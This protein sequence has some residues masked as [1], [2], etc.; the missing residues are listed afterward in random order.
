MAYGTYEDYAALFGADNLTREQYAA[1]LPRATAMLDI[2]TARRAQEATGYKLEA[3]KRAESALVNLLAAQDDTMQG[4][5][6]SSVSNEGYSES[7]KAVT[8]SDVD[9]ARRDVCRAW[10]SGTGLMSAL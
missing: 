10:L 2:Y 7:Y 9:E 3:V 4:K 8:P 1:L 6:V 5:G